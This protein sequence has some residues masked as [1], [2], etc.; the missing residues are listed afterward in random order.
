M[1]LPSYASPLVVSSSKTILSSTPVAAAVLPF[2]SA[3][4]PFTT[5]IKPAALPPCVPVFTKVNASPIS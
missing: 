1:T 5:L 2:W 4:P 3:I